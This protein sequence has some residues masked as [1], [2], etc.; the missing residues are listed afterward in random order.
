VLLVAFVIT[1]V[2]G[3]P[4]STSPAAAEAPAEGELWAVSCAGQRA[5]TA[6]GDHNSG[7][8]YHLVVKRER[9]GQWTLQQAPVP[10]GAKDA[11]LLG[12]SCTA[13]STCAAAGW[14]SKGRADRTLV[15][16]ESPEHTWSVARTPDVGPGAN[17]LDGISC[18]STDVCAAV[19]YQSVGAAYQTLVEIDR[20]GSWSVVPSPNTSPVLD[21]ALNAVSCT[22]PHDCTAVGIAR[23]VSGNLSPLVERWN[24]T[25][26][27]MVTSAVPAGSTDAE[28]YGVSCTGPST[29]TAVGQY[30]NGSSYQTLVEAWNGSGFVAVASPDATTSAQNLLQSVSCAALGHCTAVGAYFDGAS[31]RSLIETE[32]HGVWSL[33][34]PTTGSPTNFAFLYGVSCP[35]AASC[36]AV[37]GANAAPSRTPLVMTTQAPLPAIATEAPGNPLLA[38]WQTPDAQFHGPLGVAPI[39]WAHSSPSLAVGTD[40]LPRVA[41]QGPGN[42][43]DV[44]WEIWDAQWYGPLEVGGAGTSFGAPALA[45]G[46]TGL[47]TVAVQG[48]SNS[49]DV[50][51]QTPN[52]QWHGP[53]QI[54]APGTTFSS[55]SIAVAAN[56]LPTVAVEGP[57]NSLYVYWE[58]PDSQWHGPFQVALGW[59]VSAPSMTTL[60]D[61]TLSVAAQGP[62]DSLDVYWQTPNAQWHGPLQIGAPG[63]AFDSPSTTT[64]ADGLASVATEGPEHTLW[65]FWQTADAQWH[66]PFQVGAVG[67]TSAAPAMASSPSGLPDV[68]VEGPG[69]SLWLYWQTGDARWQ[70]PL[71]VGAPATAADAPALGSVA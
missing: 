28:L 14:F 12:V 59:V 62:A 66:G 70:G 24:G 31:Q 26:W 22:G 58:T 9:N 30:A 49:L 25:S 45:V 11:I 40:G 52:A 2:V 15:E 16:V 4:S 8:H 32:T 60:G 1:T 57:A 33:P 55:P 13:A 50:Y 54:G 64:G 67:S 71:G 53:L 20:G 48:P 63:S 3:V 34:P 41:V 51:W 18:S 23:G 5:C 35:T 29:C 38:F 27:T 7:G 65:F 10:R 37:G 43:L 44:Y 68:A 56:G 47:P 39:G 6:V 19:G 21:N 17:Q 42:S 61:G 46:P 36:T 69:H